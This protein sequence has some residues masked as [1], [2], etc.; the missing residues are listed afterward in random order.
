M[1]ATM[2]NVHGESLMNSLHAPGYVM[3]AGPVEQDTVGA[4]PLLPAWPSA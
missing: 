1:R 3:Q 2:F 4:V